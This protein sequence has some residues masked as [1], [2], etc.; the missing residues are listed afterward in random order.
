MCGGFFQ[1][2]SLTYKLCPIWLRQK[3]RFFWANWAFD[4]DSSSGIESP[5]FITPLITSIKGELTILIGATPITVVQGRS[6]IT[7]K[8]RSSSKIAHLQGQALLVFTGIWRPW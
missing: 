6:K 2:I 4:T 3:D 7:A 8:A 5:T 1:I